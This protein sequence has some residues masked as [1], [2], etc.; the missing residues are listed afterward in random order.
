MSWCN[1]SE[2]NAVTWFRLGFRKMGVLRMDWIKEDVKHQ[3]I[4]Q[5]CFE[6][7]GNAK[8]EKKVFELRISKRG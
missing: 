2:R 1:T 4:I 7:Y 3:K 5:A 6:M 8:M